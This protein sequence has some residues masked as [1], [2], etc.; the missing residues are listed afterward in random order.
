[1]RRLALEPV[2]LADKP[3]DVISYHWRGMASFPCRG[4]ENVSV[5]LLFYESGGSRLIQ[6]VWYS[7][8][9]SPESGARVFS[10]QFMVAYDLD[11]RRFLPKS[12]SPALVFGK[13]FQRQA[14]FS[15]E[16][17]PKEQQ[18]LFT[19]FM[20]KALPCVEPH[21]LNPA[22]AGIEEGSTELSALRQFVGDACRA[23]GAQRPNAREK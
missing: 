12:L 1:M 5:R 19:L 15:G 9:I 3:P 18:T 8:P 4:G 22:W 20:K 6:Q 11:G 14:Q 21:A 17:P 16:L 23:F 10:P 7:P 2:E 13:V